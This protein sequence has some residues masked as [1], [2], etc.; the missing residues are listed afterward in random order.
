MKFIKVLISCTVILFSLNVS[1][2]WPEKPITIIVPYAPGGINDIVTR[3]VIEDMSLLL[4]TPVTV[5][6]HAGGNGNIATSAML[7][8][9]P[10][11]TFMMGD[12][13]N[14]NGAMS[15]KKDHYNQLKPA[16]IFAGSPY[17]LVK[18]KKVPADDILDA[19]KNKKEIQVAVPGLDISS[20]IW[21]KNQRPIQVQMIPYK[22]G[23]LV[24]SAVVMGHV[25][26]GSSSFATLW[27]AIT[28]NQI[29]PVFV[30]TDKRSP[31]LPNVPT[32]KELKLTSIPNTPTEVWIALIV[33]KS[34]DA[35]IVE[36][37]NSVIA[38]AASDP[39]AVNSLNSRGAYVKVRTV[40]ESQALWNKEVIDSKKRY[41][42]K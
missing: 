14:I 25:D 18:S 9:D 31:L 16:I 13:I 39:K 22:G 24:K 37:L 36:K 8:G 34:V 30:S 6:Y 28:N 41:D 26:Y 7:N 4:K 21:I 1:A 15:T 3:S 27:D 20:A 12:Q 42:I 23:A 38:F 11:Y 19:I 17:V 29:D 2:A 35:E 10:N 32:A 5:H 40:K 33:N